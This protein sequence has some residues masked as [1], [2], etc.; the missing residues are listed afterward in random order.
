[1]HGF[2]P[3]DGECFPLSDGALRLMSMPGMLAVPVS[4]SPACATTSF[5]LTH[6]IAF[7]ASVN[8]RNKGRARS[9]AK[10]RSRCMLEYYTA[11]VARVQAS[12]PRASG[13]APASRRSTALSA[14]DAGPW[15]ARHRG[16]SWCKFRVAKGAKA[17]AR[18]EVVRCGKIRFRTTLNAQATILWHNGVQGVAGSNPAVPI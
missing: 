17:L 9:A 5:R 2:R 18:F 4:D 12:W 13:T 6:A 14:A 11:G 3:G 10:R 16:V 7:A 1:M 8:W 15:G